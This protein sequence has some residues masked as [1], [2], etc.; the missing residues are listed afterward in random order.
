MP[1]PENGTRVYDDQ[2]GVYYDIDVE[3]AY[4]QQ[5]AAERDAEKSK[6]LDINRI[7]EKLGMLSLDQLSQVE[8][9]VD[10]MKGFED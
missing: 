9:I 3:I 5:R 8:N 1:L 6:Q 10:S 7:S 4:Q 2:L